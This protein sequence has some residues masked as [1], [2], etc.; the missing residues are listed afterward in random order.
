MNTVNQLFFHDYFISRFTVNWFMVSNFHDRAF[1]INI[2]TY[3]KIGLQHEIF[4]TMRFS[5]ILWNFLEREYKW[6]YSICMHNKIITNK[7]EIVL[8]LHSC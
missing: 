6:V 8:T 1:L 4:V 5:Q 3:S 2:D 7:P